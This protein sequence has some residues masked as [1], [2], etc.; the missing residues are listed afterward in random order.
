MCWV[1][2][3]ATNKVPDM[4][5][6]SCHLKFCATVQDDDTRRAT[7]EKFID[8]VRVV[9]DDEAKA[10]VVLRRGCVPAASVVGGFMATTWAIHTSVRP[11]HQ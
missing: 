10:P 7:P 1:D 2:M 4:I 11:R 6:G 9:K 8:G 5:G 3:W